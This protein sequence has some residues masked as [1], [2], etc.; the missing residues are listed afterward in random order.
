MKRIAVLSALMLQV[1]FVATS[2]NSQGDKKLSDDDIAKLLVG[3]WRFESGPAD[4][5]LKITITFAMDKTASLEME[6]VDANKVRHEIK[7]SATWK[8]DKGNLVTTITKATDPKGVGKMERSK[9][10][11]VTEA[12]FKMVATF[13]PDNPKLKELKKVFEFK[14]VK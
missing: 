11:S 7:A 14:K 10:E 12:S 5:P 4:P 6:S 8:I 13:K 1:C 9:L 2:V 3:K